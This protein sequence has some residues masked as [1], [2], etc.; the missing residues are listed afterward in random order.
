MTDTE[1]PNPIAEGGEELK[2]DDLIFNPEN[3]VLAADDDANEAENNDIQN[4]V[5]SLNES[6]N[7]QG[8]PQG[9]DNMDNTSVPGE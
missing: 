7:E 2:A 3:D 4:D 8:I 6:A 1:Y 9:F 5:R